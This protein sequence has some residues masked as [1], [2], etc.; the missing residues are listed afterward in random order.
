[1]YYRISNY[2]YYNKSGLVTGPLGEVESLNNSNKLEL[3][4]LSALKSSLVM[5]HPSIKYLSRNYYFLPRFGFCELFP[6]VQP[7]MY[8]VKATQNVFLF[9]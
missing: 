9:A 1:M 4:R 7:P 3:F 8:T 5:R 6:F 2:I